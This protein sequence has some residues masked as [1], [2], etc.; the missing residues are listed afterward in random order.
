M[1]N[2][3][4]VKLGGESESIVLDKALLKFIETTINFYLLCG[5]SL[6]SQ[7]NYEARLEVCRSCPH[8]GDVKIEL[9]LKTLTA[10]GCTLCGCP[11][12]TKPR[13]K[14]YF[15]PKRLKM[16][17]IICPDKEG[18]KW[19]PVDQNFYKCVVNPNG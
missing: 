10:P 19:E 13:A 9:P 14:N 18:N 8:F 7:E 6:V 4:N 12:S 5:G 17:K 15:H 3:K 16:V 2:A 11:S 1:E